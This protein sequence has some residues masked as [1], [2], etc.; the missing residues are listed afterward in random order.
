V[1][2]PVQGRADPIIRLVTIKNNEPAP[3][4]DMAS[5]PLGM[6]GVTVTEAEEEADGRLSVER[7]SELMSATR[8]WSRRSGLRWCTNG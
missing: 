6:A 1:S 5:A 7:P 3:A 8:R 2:E 4:Q